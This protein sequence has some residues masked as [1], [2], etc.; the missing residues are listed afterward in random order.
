[1]KSHNKKNAMVRDLHPNEID[2]VSGG[3][4]GAVVKVI[5]RT[6]SPKGKGGKAAVAGAAAA[7]QQ[8][9]QTAE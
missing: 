6:V 7:E 2:H 9:N 3:L 5:V 8:A 1:M 4:L